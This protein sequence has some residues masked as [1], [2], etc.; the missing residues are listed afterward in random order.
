MDR[1]SYELHVESQKEHERAK[2]EKLAKSALLFS[3]DFC[4]TAAHVISHFRYFR[5]F[6]VRI[7]CLE[8][9]SNLT[10]LVCFTGFKVCYSSCQ[11]GLPG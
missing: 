1:P 9:S 3:A 10:G 11:G 8:E 4:I 2:N 6:K 7:L 5:I